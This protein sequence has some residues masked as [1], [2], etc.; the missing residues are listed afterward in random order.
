MSSIAIFLIALFFLISIYQFKK[1]KYIGK[2]SYLWLLLRCIMIFTAAI[3][4]LFPTVSFNDDKV[5]NVLLIDDSKSM[6]IYK[7]EIS[8]RIKEFNDEHK[9]K[10][11][12]I[13]YFS[14]IPYDENNYSE[15]EYTDLSQGFKNIYFDKGDK[16]LSITIFSDGLI[17]EN[18]PDISEIPKSW[19]INT[20][21]FYGKETKDIAFKE[22][23]VS[24]I[25]NNSDQTITEI[26]VTIDSTIN[27]K[28]VLTIENNERI[29]FTKDIDIV[30][31][32]EKFKIPW[33]IKLNDTSVMGRISSNEDLNPQNDFK[34]LEYLENDEIMYLVISD[35]YE[36]DEIKS[37]LDFMG[38]SEYFINTK[39]VSSSS[40]GSY[41][42]DGIILNNCDGKNFTDE[43]I[44]YLKNLVGKEGKGCFVIGGENSFGLGGYRENGLEEL[45]PVE[46]KPSGARE[47]SDSAI[48][49]VLDTSGSMDD[50][51]GGIKKINLA[52]SG[53]NSVMNQLN[54]N[55]Y[56]GVIGF[57]DTYEWVQPLVSVDEL[58]LEDKNFITLGAKGGT[59]IKPAIV[60]GYIALKEEALE[61]NKHILLI[62]DGQGDTEE[63]DDL[64]E[65]LVASK[66]TLSAIGIGEKIESDFLQE[67]SEKTNGDYYEIKNLNNLPQIMVRDV[68]K[69]GKKLL[70]SGKYKLK[71]FKG[72]TF[73][74]NYVAVTP[75]KKSEVIISTEEGDPILC[76]WK[77][78]IGNVCALMTK[79]DSSW[80]GNIVKS[81]FLEDLQTI[82]YELPLKENSDKLICK[83]DENRIDLY[84]E[85]SEPNI[86]KLDILHDGKVI[87]TVEEP[88]KIHRKISYGTLGK[89]GR[90][91]I[92]GYDK[93]GNSV[94][95]KNIWIDYSSENNLFQKPAWVNNS[96]VFFK[97][98]SLNSYK[99]IKMIYLG[100]PILI[101][102]FIILVYMRKK[103]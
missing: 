97:K 94:F 103:Y 26:E 62:S 16:N 34:K 19:T 93:T 43:G 101:I 67:I 6:N 9:G 27:C 38:I 59:L 89:T 41:D 47:E 46:D 79:I 64:I 49:I 11:I 31:G 102:L 8:R 28:A 17:T 61:K 100:W 91:Q 70:Q 65:K 50:N 1:I 83:I 90:Y 72:N 2:K 22:F 56:F 58:N 3:V 85:Y 32:T 60:H 35:D 95:L 39:N 13:Y 15:S 92:N 84:S 53:L 52:K 76:E 29:V 23:R 80:S 4:I 87:Y 48:V 77:F 78:G 12:S 66:I 20:I 99:N 71:E 25:K 63:Y 30:K 96:E 82:L 57:S 55:D 69:N 37:V 81:D 74:N 75:K 33:E 7:D 21:P 18:I 68:Y 42:F 73:I 45:M 24:K 86:S 51:S 36:N 14:G 44:E 40:F 5:E 54:E 98:N 88:F 10:E